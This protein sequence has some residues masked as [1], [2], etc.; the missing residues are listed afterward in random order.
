MEE[1]NKYTFNHIDIHL[2]QRN[3]NKYLTFIEG[4]DKDERKFLSYLKKNLNVNGTIIKDNNE[5]SIIH[6]SGDK[7]KEV[8]DLLLKLRIIEEENITI[9]GY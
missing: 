4:I 2:K 9:H 7:R 5:R 6:L 3:T 1:E 8:K